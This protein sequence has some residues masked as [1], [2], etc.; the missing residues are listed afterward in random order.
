[1]VWGN[2]VRIGNIR[3]DVDNG[4]NGAVVFSGDGGQGVSW[5]NIVGCDDAAG[6]LA[7]VVGG[8]ADAFQVGWESG[9]EGEEGSEDD[10]LHDWKDNKRCRESVS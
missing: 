3:I 4:S 1:L 9:D 8:L 5:A 10:E 6:V 2:E 7:G